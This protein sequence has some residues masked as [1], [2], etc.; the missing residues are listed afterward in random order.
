MQNTYVWLTVLSAGFCAALLVGCAATA[1]TPAG[2]I[3]KES[4]G[5]T[6]DGTP[7]DIY[8]LRNRKGVEARICNYGGI[9]VSLKVPDRSG[10]FGDVVLGYDNLADYIKETPY[11]GCLVGR[12]GN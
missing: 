5:Q 4:F 9:V 6:P 12:Y 10:Q 3:G 8:T 1:P 7:V 2:H 11:F